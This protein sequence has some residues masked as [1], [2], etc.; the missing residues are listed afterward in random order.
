[1]LTRIK[2]PSQP[3]L[4]P[5]QDKN[6]GRVEYQIYG[7]SHRRTYSKATHRRSYPRAELSTGGAIPEQSYPQAELSTGG[8]N[9][10]RSHPQTCPQAKPSKK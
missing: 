10:R 9:H 7:Y 2:K 3:S 1:M 5:T 6:L 8:V 4:I